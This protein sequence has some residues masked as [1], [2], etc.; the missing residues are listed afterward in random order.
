MEDYY[1]VDST[2]VDTED[3]V[4]LIHPTDGITEYST[5]LVRNK[6]HYICATVK[7]DNEIST[8]YKI[9]QMNKQSRINCKCNVNDKVYIVHFPE[10]RNIKSIEILPFADTIP[11][12][13]EI[14][15]EE[16]LGNYF[17]NKNR[18]VKVGH[19]F[20]CN[21]NYINIEFKVKSIDFHEKKKISQKSPIKQIEYDTCGIFGENVMC[22][23]NGNA[24]VRSEED[25]KQYISYE[26]IGG[27][28]HI[29]RELREICELPV[30]YP[31]I[32]ETIGIKAPKGVLFHGP[33]GTGKTLLA[34]A[35]ANE[36]KCKFICV[37]SPEIVAA[38]P[39]ES[40]QLLKSIFEDAEENK[41]AII[42]FDE[43]DAIGPKREKINSELERRIVAQLLILMDGIKERGQIIVI[44]ATNRPNSLEPALRRFG[45]F[46]KEIQIGVPDVEGRAE[47]LKIHTK[48][49]RLGQDV[50]INK[51]AQE[52]HGFVGADL[53]Q[54]CSEA[55]MHVINKKINISDLD[56]K[57]LNLDVLNSLIVCQEDFNIVKDK[58]SPST[59]RETVVERPTVKWDDIGGLFDTKKELQ[60][61]IQYPIQHKNLYSEFNTKPPSGILLFGPPGCGKTLLA[62][63]I[64][65]ETEMNFIS[66]KGPEFFN[67]WV[68]ESEAK[69]RELFDKARQA[70]PCILFLDEIDSI[71]TKR[72]SNAG[73]S[74]VG[75]RVLNQLLTEMDGMSDKKNVFVIGATNRPDILDEAIMRPGRLGLHI[76]VP[77]GDKD[78][79]LSILSAR[80]RK[81]P[82]DEDI[83]LEELAE[84]TEG[85]SGA[86]LSAICDYAVKNAIR[87][88]AEKEKIISSEFKRS[89]ILSA[90]SNK[91]LDFEYLAKLTN[92]FSEYNLNNV[93][94]QSNSIEN[95]KLTHVVEIIEAE[96]INKP[97]VILN[98]HHI[99]SALDNV[100]KSVS[101][102][103]IAKF[104]N[105]VSTQKVSNISGF[106]FSK[107]NKN[108]SNTSM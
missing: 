3:N 10:I 16:I 52:T 89:E 73:D 100:N 84:F 35:I 33:P 48:K 34:K 60:E 22:I 2:S 66:V 26:D 77:L 65:T 13:V 86:D 9:V 56:Y 21:N 102:E 54:L 17:K 72:G 19:Q 1:T 6:N 97:L 24:L 14:N 71:A 108:V 80:L 99:E 70:A 8:D 28:K 92:G 67:M 12:N 31:E 81:T 91:R 75:E 61:T 101:P 76:Y 57:K 40:E 93:V 78:S 42:F 63:A 107:K 43:F 11:E 46:D 90:I 64:A 104:L 85:F 96:K 49:I 50:N 94:T 32:F 7:F 106:K 44:G 53:A 37:N 55:G 38:K 79:R 105:Y 82:M 45:R 51:I 74:G 87:D 25:I 30:K 68:G 27:C 59:L 98:T 41:P 5:V 95:V 15:F 18:L 29:I 88:L 23:A 36:C 62:K 4:V 20:T 39:G 47:I 103:S 58:I 69:V 83:D